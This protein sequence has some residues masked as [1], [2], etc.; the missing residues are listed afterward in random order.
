MMT[1]ATRYAAT[2]AL[3]LATASPA[4]ALVSEPESLFWGAA[5]VNG[6]VFTGEVT[7]LIDGGSAEPVASYAMGSK[8]DYGTQYGLFV[9][10]DSVEPQADGTARPGDLLRFYLDG[11]LASVALLSDRGS[12]QQLDLDTNFDDVDLSVSSFT[13]LPNPVLAGNDLVYSVTVSNAGPAVEPTAGF[14]MGLAGG[15][16]FASAT[17]AVCSE[18]GGIVTCALGQ[19]A[20]SGSSAVSITVHTAASIANGSELSATA[21]TTHSADTTDIDATDDS[22]NVAV[23]VNRQADLDIVDPITLG[24]SG[25]DTPDP[26][27]AGANL[28]LSVTAIN[29]G[30][31]DSGAAQLQI[32]LPSGLTA[33]T[34]VVGQTACSVAAQVVTCA[35][36]AL[37]SGTQLTASITAAVASSVAH[38]SVV[39]TNATL[40]GSPSYDPDGS[41]ARSENTTVLRQSDL[42]LAAESWTTS[43]VA[44]NAISWTFE[45]SNDGP[46]D[47]ASVVY[48]S[49]V[50]PGVQLDA[51]TPQGACALS[52]DEVIC[53]WSSIAAGQSQTIDID[54]TVSSDVPQDTVLS[55]AASVTTPTE[56]DTSDNDVTVT[57]TTGSSADLEV[58]VADAPDPVTAGEKLQYTITVTNNGPS[59]IAG[60]TLVDTLPA[61]LSYDSVSSQPQPVLYSIAQDLPKLYTVD[62]STGAVITSLDLTMAA[63]TVVGGHGL[64][65]HPLTGELW[66]LLEL[67]DQTGYELAVIDATTGLARRVGDTGD[68]FVALAFGADGTLYAMTDDSTFLAP[69]EQLFSLSTVDATPSG[70]VDV[71][72]N[73]A[74]EALAFRSG[75]GR[76]YQ[77]S[78]AA[79]A[80]DDVFR[81]IDPETL[82]ETLLSSG[83]SFDSPTALALTAA[84]DFLLGDSAGRLYRMTT[85]GSASLI[86]YL[87]PTHVTGGLAYAGMAACSVNGQ[88]ITCGLGGMAAAQTLTLTLTAQVGV[89]VAGQVANSATAYAATADPDTSNNRDIQTTTTVNQP[90]DEPLVADLGVEAV[91]WTTDVVA[92]SE[93]GSL[94]WTFEVSNLGPDDAGAVELRGT[95][96]PGVAFNNATPSSACALSGADVVCQYV[97]LAND[98]SQQVTITGTVSANVPD[99]ETLS[100]T[101]TATTARDDATANNS[102]TATTAVEAIADVVLTATDTP[103]PATAGEDLTYDV[104]ISNSG[105]SRAAAVQLAATLAT[106]VSFKSASTAQQSVLYSV[107]RADGK[108]YVLDP[109]TAERTS[110][111]PIVVPGAVV[112]GGHGLATHPQTGELWALLELFGQ[113]GYELVVLDSATGQARRIGNTA[114]RYVALAFSEAGTL[115]A[116]T[117]Q[118]TVSAPTERLFVISTSN[119]TAAAL[120]SLATSSAG[121]ALA[122]RQSDHLLYQLSGETAGGTETFRAVNPGTFATTYVPITGSFQAP[123]AMT[124]G[125]DGELLLTDVGGNLYRLSAAGAVTAIGAISPAHVPGGIAF[126]PLPACTAAGQS[127]SCDL[128]GIGT[129]ET[130]HIGLTVTVA[131]DAPS[132]VTS[133]FS[134]TAATQDSNATNNRNVSVATQTQAPTVEADLSLSVDTAVQRDTTG[135]VLAYAITVSNAGRSDADAVVLTAVLPAETYAE[136]LPEECAE[137]SGNQVVCSWTSLASGQSASV[138]LVARV[139]DRTTSTFESD[140]SVTSDTPDPDLDNNAVHVSTNQASLCELMSGCFSWELVEGDMEADRTRVRFS[141]R[142]TNHCESPLAEAV[143]RFDPDGEIVAPADGSAYTSAGGATYTVAYVT[144]PRRGI[145]FRPQQTGISGGSSDTFVFHA[146]AVRLFASTELRNSAETVGGGFGGF[147]SGWSTCFPQSPTLSIAKAEACANYE[148]AEDMYRVSLSLTRHNWSEAYRYNIYRVEAGNPDPVLLTQ[149]PLDPSSTGGPT[150]FE[151]AV[152]A[153]GASLPRYRFVPVELDNARQ[154]DAAGYEIQAEEGCVVN[155]VPLGR[156]LALALGIAAVSAG[157]LARR[158][159]QGQGKRRRRGAGLA[160]LMA[161]MALLAAA[162]AGPVPVHAAAA[163]SYQGRLLDEDATPGGAAVSGVCDFRFSLHSALAGEGNQIGSTITS[164]NVSV[165]DGLFSVDLDFGASA[166]SGADRYL[167]ISVQCEGDDDF[168]TLSPRQKLAM[169]PQAVYAGTAG[170]AGNV[171]WTGISGVPTGLADGDDDTTYTAD[172]T[173]LSLSGTAFSVKS[174]GIDT[175]K[176]S[177]NPGTGTAGQLLGSSGSG[178]FSWADDKDTTYTADEATLSLSGT[179]FGVKAAG[180]GTTQLT[181]APGWGTPGQLLAADGAGGFAWANDKDTTYTADENSLTLSGTI[182]GVKTAGVATDHL[183]GSPGLGTAGQILSADGSGGFSWTNDQDTTYTADETSVTLSGT[184]FGIKNAGV[185]AAKLGGS[186]GNGTAGQMLTASGTGG[187]AWE[188]KRTADESSLTLS[189]GVYSIRTAGVTAAKLSGSPGNGTAGDVLASDGAGGFDWSASSDTLWSRAGNSGTVAGT[190]YLG[191]SDD[192]PLEMKVNGQTALRLEPGDASPN[193]IA[194]NSGNSAGTGVVG[195]AIGGGGLTSAEQVV[196]DDYGTVAGGRGNQAGNASGTASDA[197]DATVG[198]GREN[199]ASATWTTVA[200]GWSN[201]ANANGATVSGGQSN[202]ASGQFNVVAGGATNT[203]D[204]TT[205]A[206]IGGGEQNA[207]SQ[208]YATVPGGLKAK[209]DKYGQVAHAS[210]A[211]ASPGDAQT[212]SFVLRQTTTNGTAASMFLDGGSYRMTIPANTAWAVHAMVVASTQN[213]NTTDGWELNGIIR[214]SGGATTATVS[215]TQIGSQSWSAALSADD[216]NDAL[217]IT[218]TGAAA[219]TIRWVA[220]VTTAEVTF[221]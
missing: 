135:Q 118:T 111:V 156:P 49:D 55:V 41:D 109:E 105:P 155:Q 144:T 21:A 216:A 99:G 15:F 72:T 13:V 219:T 200:G 102:A 189:G 75:N 27:V 5:T 101:M 24:Q 96:P 17:P 186:P 181:G 198:G 151:D 68:Y 1:R 192:E 125:D 124:P 20:A 70:L 18:T 199:T 64:A 52:G 80:G 103:D 78:G 169:S 29:R 220:H 11:V 7:V 48:R 143:F 98:S 114:D 47:A 16:T 97:S 110:F 4:A 77:L 46:S 3:L 30:P 42:V 202:A 159:V 65:V 183:A 212:S 112:A 157:M 113:T 34:A 45:V 211:F 56:S 35:L 54:G 217:V 131:E 44:A 175:A 129:G 88:N 25:L 221:P 148:V 171:P 201:T 185:T 28:S 66:A 57:T 140:V 92:A 38:N 170:A 50:P 179:V 165:T 69:A 74:G 32:V 53:Q 134:T 123:T 210:G 33:T 121:E 12:A 142:L 116:M 8:P 10:I 205:Y 107:A 182:F 90:P 37:T 83:G 95:L 132:S 207:A 119:A 213:A 108:L 218:V 61:G 60:V 31:S 184:A 147:A 153:G 214:N 152:L 81:S 150:M 180:I 82:Q 51:V 177:G 43:V 160:A 209:A 120:T 26:V 22:A 76:L 117:D 194:G 190:D 174:A 206:T 172:G 84:D 164:N 149:T 127:V 163:I 39:A 122:Y 133:T 128:S 87:L 85:G 137:T 40:T 106:G 36:G 63:E 191:T 158:R 58:T 62:A 162:V 141:W 166:F 203:A 23:T 167:Q 161:L 126:A 195:A 138:E 145:V 215:G 93:S 9:P 204:G 14:T 91:S 173:S 154:F 100:F 196:T 115:Y 2:A 73:A 67:D 208:Y 176:L 86:G 89:A 59:R 130:I 94:T 136:V 187:F 139:A 79:S 197:P 146:D 168:S 71:L 19:I 104:S 193:V 6:A 188:T 178:G